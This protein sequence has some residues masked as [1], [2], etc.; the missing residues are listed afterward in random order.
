MPSKSRTDEELFNYALQLPELL[1][2]RDNEHIVLVLDEFQEVIRIAGEDTLKGHALLLSETR[3][4]CLF[5][6][7]FKRRHDEYYFW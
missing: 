4:R 6:S 3:R 1:A 2:K 7:W 5:V